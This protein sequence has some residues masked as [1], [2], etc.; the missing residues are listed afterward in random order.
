MKIPVLL[1]AALGVVAAASQVHAQAQ[2]YPNRT[3]RGYTTGSAGGISDIFMR[4]LGIELSKRWGQAFVV[5]NRPGGAQN[6]GTRA[7]SEA[8]PGASSDPKSSIHLSPSRERAQS[9]RHWAP[10]S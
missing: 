3:V 7:C 4:A 6:V 8:P 1:F 2:D 10:A 9:V 5:E